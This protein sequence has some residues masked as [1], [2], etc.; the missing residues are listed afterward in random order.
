MTVD[1]IVNNLK[2]NKEY[3]NVKKEEQFDRFVR[4]N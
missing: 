1:E 3:Y 4:G 2:S